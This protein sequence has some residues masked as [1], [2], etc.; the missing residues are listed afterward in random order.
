MLG[1]MV[2][3]YFSKKGFEI[4]KISERY[5]NDIDNNFIKSIKEAG[6]GWIINCVG[7][8]KQKTQNPFELYWSNSILPLE[9]I[10]NISSNQ[11][12]IHPS[13]DCVFDGT[14]I[15]PYDI[16]DNPNAMDDYG[17]SKYFGECV[18]RDKIN[19]LV[20]RVS[21]IGLDKNENPKGLLGWFLNQDDNSE[22]NG[23]INHLWN[24]I[25]TLEWCK[26]VENIMENMEQYSKRNIIQLGTKEIYT[27]YEMLKLF[28]VVFNK[29]HIIHE[30]KTSEGI[31]RCL[32]PEI[33]C[34]N[35]YE[36][37]QELKALDF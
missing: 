18:L 11:F 2:S 12:L 28:N 15:Q 16:L 32:N 8:I 24:G 17:K 5:T 26:Q 4:L 7:K 20:I 23:F 13:T 34:K 25:T 30:Y 19:A 14:S 3:F 36:Q 6:E 29:N 21:I 10:T 35:L 9:I 22:L 1:Q 27:K 37:L 31:N 33:V